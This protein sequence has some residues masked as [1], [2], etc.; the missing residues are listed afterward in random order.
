MRTVLLPN[1]KKEISTERVGEFEIYDISLIGP[2]IRTADGEI[3]VKK[4][5]IVSMYST[6]NIFEDLYSNFL[7]GS[8]VITDATNL[9]GEFPIVGDEKVE[10]I[11][12]SINTPVSIISIM[13]VTGI[14]EMARANELTNIY[15]LHLTS[16]IAIRSE[17]QKLSRSFPKGNV[18][19]IVKTICEDYLNMTYD[20]TVNYIQK[21]DYRIKDKEADKSYFSL[22][23]ASTN[24]EK[25]VAPYSS[26][27][28]I[29]NTLC[30]R[31][32]N[33]DGSL[34]FFYEDVDQFHFMSLEERLRRLKDKPATRFV[35]FPAN[36]TSNIPLRL[37]IGAWSTVYDYRIKEKFDV[38]K[39]MANGMYS[40]EIT[41]VDPEKRI[42]N[43]NRYYYQKDAK[44]YNHVPNKYLLTSSQ[45]DLLHNEQ[46]EAPRTVKGMMT[47]HIGDE[48]SGDFTIH[49]D[50]YIQRRMSMVAQMQGLTLE[51]EIPGDTSGRVSVG[52]LIEFYIPT[53]DENDEVI[54]DPILSGKYLVTR[55]RHLVGRAEKYTMIIEI[56]SDTLNSSHTPKTGKGEAELEE[57][58][59]E[60][61]NETLTVH[62]DRLGVPTSEISNHY[63]DAAHAIDRKRRLAN[64]TSFR[65]S[66]NV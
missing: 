57:T 4:L 56:V 48:P 20:I 17:K 31:S 10:I 8:I 60:F 6:F 59:I 21:G 53:L 15:T 65:D 28:K 46:M 19:R 61:E 13:R 1:E 47:F 54:A 32:F 9:I 37:N 16:E 38:L 44:K 11:F 33:Q 23:S 51:L 52:Q 22:E 26:P 2:S 39:N 29:I 64:L 18:H 34:Y 24:L 12:R 5:S 45:S 41:F 27:M 30:K 7:T 35:Y 49:N 58:S 25:Y 63:V 43:T 40:S 42:A 50:Q 55:I 66:Q 36:A 3:Q 14:S 62:P